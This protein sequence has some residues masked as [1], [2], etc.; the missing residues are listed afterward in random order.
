MKKVDLVVIGGG[1]A[2]MAAAVKAKEKGVQDVLI[3]ERENNL[4]GILNQCIHNGFGLHYFGEE[5]TGPEYAARFIDKVHRMNIPYLLET[6]VL[7]I[8]SDKT[9]TAVNSAEG[10]FTIKAKSII[11]AMGCRERTRGALNIPGTRP[12][13]IY[14]AGTAQ[15]YVNICGYMPGKS[16]VI[17]GS[18]D[19][20]LIMARRLALEGAQVKMV[21]ELLPYSSGLTRN[22]VQCLDDYSIPLRLNHT[23]IAVHG[24]ERLEGVTVAEVDQD[25]KP[26]PETAEFVPCDTLLLSVGLIPE[27]ELSRDAGIELDPVTSGPV[28]DNRMETLVEGIFACGNVAHVHDLVDNVSNESELAGESAA[29]YILGTNVPD[30]EEAI[31]VKAGNGIRYTVPRIIRKQSLSRN[32]VKIFFR[33]ADVNRNVKLAARCGNNILLERKKVKVTPG[34]METL[35]LKAEDLQEIKAGEELVIEVKTNGE[36]Q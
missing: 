8:D 15:K 7:N 17:L 3:L 24:K 19:I 13:G 31:T 9:V 10:V 35:E 5:L 2:G 25:R 26:I 32:S 36:G 28:V 22:I 18:G 6:M 16:V 12:S 21:C 20:G 33:V 4:G 30:R 1:P 34:E 27:N 14:T 23:V 11:L 29:E